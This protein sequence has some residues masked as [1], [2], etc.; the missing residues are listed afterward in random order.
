[1]ESAEDRQVDGPVQLQSEKNRQTFPERHCAQKDNL[2]A[3]E[4]Q[5]GAARGVR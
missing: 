2:R 5:S 1:M 3:T 4:V